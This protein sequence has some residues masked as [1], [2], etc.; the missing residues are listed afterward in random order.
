MTAITQTNRLQ[1]EPRR[2]PGHEAFTFKAEASN[3]SAR[4]AVSES[5]RGTD[6][7]QGFC[8]ERVASSSRARAA[9]RGRGEKVLVAGGR[10]RGPEEG[11]D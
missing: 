6:W 2:Q 4:Q 11:P 1:I 8:V 5:S 10:G 9:H 7:Q 3:H